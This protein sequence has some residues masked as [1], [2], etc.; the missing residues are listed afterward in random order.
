MV[1]A[2]LHSSRWQS[3]GGEEGGGGGGVIRLMNSF[4]ASSP[5]NTHMLV[6]GVVV[7]TRNLFKHDS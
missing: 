3:G 5:N 4:N 2:R 1:I 7:N 6:R